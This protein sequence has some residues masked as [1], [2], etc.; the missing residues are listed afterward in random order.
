MTAPER[1]GPTIKRLR[2]RRGLSQQQLQY[3]LTPASRGKGHR[4]GT[5][6]RIEGGSR[7]ATVPL[8]A[9]IADAL[10]LD[11]AERLELI[12]AAGFPITAPSG[13]GV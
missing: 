8:L 6:C 5:L 9:R 2:A 12:E 7:G 10:A 11:P 13:E 1:L 3:R 4:P